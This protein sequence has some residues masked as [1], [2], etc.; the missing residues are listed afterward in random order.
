MTSAIRYDTLPRPP[1]P[2]REDYW[3]T[4]RFKKMVEEMTLLRV[5]CFH[6]CGEQGW[7]SAESTRLPPM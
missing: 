1:F 3:N 4:W 6:F 5:S 7:C 2:P